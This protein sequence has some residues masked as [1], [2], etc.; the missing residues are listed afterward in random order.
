MRNISAPMAW[1]AVQRRDRTFDG[2]F[3]Y[4]VRSTRI[5]CRPSCPSRRPTRSR[6]EFFGTTAEAELAGY[7][8]CRRCRPT[9]NDAA[10]IDKAIA[11]AARYL[12]AHA[13]EPVT[14]DTLSRAVGVSAFH[15]QREFKRALGVSPREFRDAERRRRLA[16]RLRKG[17]TVSRATFDA[18]FGSSSRV[19]ERSA[20][21]MGMTPA[22]VR[23]GGAGERMQFGIVDSRLGRLLAAYT[24]HGVCAVAIGDDDRAL[25]QQLRADFSEADIR[26]AGPAIHEWITAIVRGL[27]GESNVGAIPLDVRGTAFQRRV[28]NALQQIPRGTTLSYGQVAS[29]IGQPQAARAVARACATNPVALVIPC[30]RV[31]REDGTLGGYRWGVE[32]K[33]RLLA[34]EAAG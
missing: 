2:T 6:V 32:R 33:E 24:E 17:D 30:H 7:R 1:R 15:L 21:S 10:R 27:D 19:Y 31:V 11:R 3:V 29:R 9:S 26:A 5:F 25:E 16:E 4:A 8:P 28:W 12:T 18:G 14:L 34:D 13:D 23:K 20:R 22:T